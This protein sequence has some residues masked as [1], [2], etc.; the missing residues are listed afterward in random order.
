MYFSRVELWKGCTIN[1]MW[2]RHRYNYKLIECNE[3]NCQFIIYIFNCPIWLIV[4]NSLSPF[5]TLCLWKNNL[6]DSLLFT[7][8][9][10]LCIKLGSKEIIWIV[11][12]YVITVYCV[13]Q[14]F[15]M[16]HP[17][18]IQMYV[19]SDIWFLGTH[20]NSYMPRNKKKC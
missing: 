6:R 4:C 7:A 10:N 5:T 13:I 11:K 2:R 20:V 12:I 3:N 9:K 18:E 15:Y 1:F 19:T 16:W 8:K 17:F 14:L